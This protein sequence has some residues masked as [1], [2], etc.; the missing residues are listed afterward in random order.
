VVSCQSQQY[1]ICSVHSVFTLLCSGVAAIE[2]IDTVL[3][4]DIT[5]INKPY[6][7]EMSLELTLF[8]HS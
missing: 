3:T 7:K 6:F 8:P 4:I 1:N 5:N 2:H